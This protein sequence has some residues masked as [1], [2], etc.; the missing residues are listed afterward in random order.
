[1]NIKYIDAS[2]NTSSPMFLGFLISTNPNINEV[3]VLIKE[4]L[5]SFVLFLYSI[6]VDINWAEKFI[7]A[8]I[9]I[10]TTNEV[11]KNIIFGSIKLPRNMYNI[12]PIILLTS[13]LFL[14]IYMKLC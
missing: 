3:I 12:P 14:K 1:M 11:S 13:F 5:H 8:Y 9:P 4:Y 2:F 7:S 10:I 6:K